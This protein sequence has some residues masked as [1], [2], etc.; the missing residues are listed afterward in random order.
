[1]ELIT[2]SEMSQKWNLSRR[3]IATLCKEGRIP[4]SI[5]KGN[6]WLI[7]SDSTKPQDARHYRY[8]NNDSN[9]G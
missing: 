3:R 6:V 8:K 5:L 9:K 1:M 4:G 7:P 2:T